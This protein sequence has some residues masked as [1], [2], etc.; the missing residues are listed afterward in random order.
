MSKNS[1]L[2]PTTEQRAQELA[3]EIVEAL[4]Q[5]SS[6]L[7][8]ALRKFPKDVIAPLLFP[9]L[10]AEV[11]RD[12][13]R[14]RLEQVEMKT[15]HAYDQLR[16]ERDKLKLLINVDPEVPQSFFKGALEAEQLISTQLREE[17]DNFHQEQF[18]IREA[19][20]CLASSRPLI[21]E[22][23]D[24]IKA[25]TQLRSD[26]QALREAL[27][28]ILPMAKGYAFQHRVGN[29][30]AMI[31]QATAALQQLKSKGGEG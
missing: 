16:E 1:I 9:L 3:R 24:F 21:N 20:H 23:S 29:N 13:A 25:H 30:G 28:L 6:H 17:R 18:K 27:E 26:N 19:L 7:S 4:R 31:K 14:A 2:P 22:I 11:E 5:N 8:N 10:T 15:S 12:S